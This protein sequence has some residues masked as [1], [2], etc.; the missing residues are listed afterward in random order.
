LNL[1]RV[2]PADMDFEF[3]KGRA[4]ECGRKF[5][6]PKNLAEIEGVLLQPLVDLISAVHPVLIPVID[7][8]AGKRF[9]SHDREFEVA[10]RGRIKVAHNGPLDRAMVR[11][12]TRSIPSSWRQKILEA[13][14]FICA[15]CGADLRMTGHEIDHIV[16]FSK[17]GATVMENLQALCPKCNSKKGNR[18]CR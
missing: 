2:A 12:Y 8:Y 7:Q 13:A 4:I 5:I 14:A 16:P 6:W 17:G 1:P 10:S 11:Q 3:V 9:T 15:H 18:Y